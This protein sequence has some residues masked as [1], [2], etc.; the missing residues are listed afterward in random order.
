VVEWPD[1]A[2]SILQR[3]KTEDIRSLLPYDGALVRFAAAGVANR[4]IAPQLV[5][6]R[7]GP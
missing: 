1:A 6:T 3:I 2:L 7:W 4:V 5:V